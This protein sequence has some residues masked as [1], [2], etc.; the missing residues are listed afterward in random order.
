MNNKILKEVLIFALL[1]LIIIFAISILFYDCMSADDI[2]FSSISY[3]ETE[4]VKLALDEIENQSGHISTE[5]DGVVLKSYSVNV[6]ETEEDGNTIESGK[7][8]PFTKYNSTVDEEV[9]HTIISNPI[10][11][12]N[13][14]TSN[15]VNEVDGYT[16]SE[17]K[18][19]DNSVVTGSVS[20]TISNTTSTTGTY[21]EKPNS[22]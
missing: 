11:A 4:N 15:A 6:D 22:K 12:T 20:N 5:E 21:F 18:T 7:K 2:E 10:T 9:V 17:N 8:D 14:Q 3:Q 19:N 1:F 13:S 16:N